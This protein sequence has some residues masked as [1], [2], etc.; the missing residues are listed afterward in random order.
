MTDEEFNQIIWT[1]CIHICWP[2]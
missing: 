1:R 2:G